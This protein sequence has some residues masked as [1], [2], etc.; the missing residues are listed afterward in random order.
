MG[1]FLLLFL[2]YIYIICI[3]IYRYLYMFTCMCIHVGIYLSMCVLLLI[4]LGECSFITPCLQILI[5][6]IGEFDVP[7]FPSFL[8]SWY[9]HCCTM[10][11]ILKKKILHSLFFMFLVVVNG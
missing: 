5:C 9:I 2:L 10:L 4:D 3:S 11:H 7:F 8:F 6:G 1:E